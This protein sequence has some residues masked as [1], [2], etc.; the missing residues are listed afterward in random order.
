MTRT[1]AADAATTLALKLL[2]HLLFLPFSCSRPMARR[3]P[4]FSDTRYDLSDDFWALNVRFGRRA[5]CA[6][7]TDLRHA[8]HLLS[9]VVIHIATLWLAESDKFDGRL[10]IALSTEER[11]EQQQRAL[12]A[13]CFELL[14]A[15]L[16]KRA[17]EPKPTEGELEINNYKVRSVTRTRACATLGRIAAAG[18]A[19]MIE[20]AVPAIVH[21]LRTHGAEEATHSDPAPL[22]A[23]RKHAMRKL[24]QAGGECAQAVLT[25]CGVDSHQQH[26]LFEWGE[27]AQV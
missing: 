1:S 20:V 10:R 5:L 4:F 27:P 6:D 21:V 22:L 7:I 16:Q 23:E 26:A 12:A 13:G 8:A 24:V 2:S 17:L 25:S 18:G 3:T 9:S 15:V 11:V 19:R 14:I